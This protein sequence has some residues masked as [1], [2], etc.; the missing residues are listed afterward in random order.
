M[1]E[2][3]K[4]KAKAAKAVFKKLKPKQ[5]SLE[6]PISRPKVT[7]LPEGSDEEDEE[8]NSNDSDN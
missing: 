4:K 7:D 2:D 1:W 3:E 6:S 5:E 8:D